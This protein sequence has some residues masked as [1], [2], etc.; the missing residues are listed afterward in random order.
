MPLPTNLKAE[1]RVDLPMLEGPQ[2]VALS[3]T[4]EWYQDQY[5]ECAANHN[6]L[7]EALKERGIQ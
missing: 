1:C 6:G 7:I 3:T 2:G 4:L 5:T